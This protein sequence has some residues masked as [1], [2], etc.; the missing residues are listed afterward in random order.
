MNSALVRLILSVGL[1]CSIASPGFAQ[2]LHNDTKKFVA[3]SQMSPSDWTNP[4][5]LARTWNAAVV[6]VPTGKGRSKKLTTSRLTGW[7]PSKGQKVPA[8]IYM[9]G[10]TGVWDGTHYRVKLMADLGFLVVAPASLAREKRPQSCDHKTHTGGMYRDVLPL[11]QNDAA[12]AIQRVRS[13]PYV[14]QN[15]VILMGLS[16]GGITAATYKARSANT[17]VTHRIIEGWPCHAGWR[18]YKGIN[19]SKDEPVMSLYGVLDPWFQ[20]DWSRGH[21]GSFMNR[22]NGSASYV[23]KTG[24]L[25]RE[26][27]LLEHSQP[28][29]ALRQFLQAHQL[30]Q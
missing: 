7:T 4:N 3:P 19:A 16:E 14:D 8:V 15:T 30:I 22:N 28:R 26:H 21:C 23:F 29:Q 9:H 1:A 10:C 12:Y 18:E 27:E 25:A 11:R 20:N 5:E 6:R 17:R 2:A 24:K 13:L